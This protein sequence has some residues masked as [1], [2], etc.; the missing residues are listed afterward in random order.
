LQKE[1]NTNVS[2]SRDAVANQPSTTNTDPAQPDYSL[3]GF[4]PQASLS[5]ST[6]ALEAL[7]GYR[8]TTVMKYENTSNSTTQS[9]T[10][11]VL[12]EYVDQAVTILQ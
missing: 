1:T 3:A 5:S 9:E 12:G 2:L 8:Y 6:Q 7:D 4:E 11:T 10:T